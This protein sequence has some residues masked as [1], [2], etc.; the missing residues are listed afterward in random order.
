MNETIINDSPHFR[1]K[2]KKWKCSVPSDLNTVEF[3]RQVLD[4]D[5]A[6]L[7]TSTYQFFMTDLQLNLLAE[8]ITK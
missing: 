7:S 5:G 3:I 1:L 4:K 8:E 6:I 2:I